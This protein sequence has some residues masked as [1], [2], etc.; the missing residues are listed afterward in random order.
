MASGPPNQ[1]NICCPDIGNSRQSAGVC[2]ND[3][4]QHLGNKCRQ[5]YNSA[6]KQMQCFV[7]LYGRN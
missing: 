2:I 7:G 4:P 5:D 3:I 6:E 1:Q